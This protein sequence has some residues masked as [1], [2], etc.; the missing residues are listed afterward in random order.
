MSF[1]SLSS[2]IKFLEQKNDLVRIRA[3]VDPI[4]EIT[5]I[6]TRIVAQ[7]GPALLFEN[8]KGSKF[9]LVINI[10]GTE[11]RVEWALGRTPDKV[12]KELGH[13]A[14]KLMPPSPRVLW[15]QRNVIGRILSMRPK[16]M[17]Q[18]P[19]LRNKIEPADLNQ[20]PIAQSWPLDGGR[21]CAIGS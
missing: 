7:K 8:V 20:L 4:L 16:K 17:Y 19:V 13:F 10:L 3:E 6:T 9:P 15:D 11:K 12:G 2:F 18:A 14:E 21:D 1:R 5:E